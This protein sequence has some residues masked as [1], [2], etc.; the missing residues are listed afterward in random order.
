MA[1]ISGVVTNY[2]SPPWQLRLWSAIFLRG[3]FRDDRRPVYW[4]A[5]ACGDAGP[6]QVSRLGGGLM[7][8][9]PN[10]I[11]LVRFDESLTGVCD[12]GD[13]DFCMQLGPD[14]RL[15]VAP[16]ARLVHN[17]S[18]AGRTTGHW[19][20]HFS[21]TNCHLFY[22]NWRKGITNL[23][24]F[25]WLCVGMALAATAG[26][27]GRFSAAPWV[28]LLGGIRTGRRSAGCDHARSADRPGATAAAHKPG[29][30]FERK[31]CIGLIG[32]FLLLLGVVLGL[33]WFNH[34]YRGNF[35]D[36]PDESA[37][38]VT[39]L[40]VHDYLSGLHYLHPMRFAEDFYLHYPK[41][42]FGH[43]PPVFY[44]VQTVW[45]LLFST[46]HTSLMLLMAV[47]TAL[48][49]FSVFWMLDSRCG[50]SCAVAGAL[51]MASLPV[52]QSEVGM[53][54]ADIPLALFT[55]LA[56][57]SFARFLDGGRTRDALVFGGI[58]AIAVMTKGSALALALL[59]FVAIPLTKKWH[60]FRRP[61][62]WAS[63]AIVVVLCAPWYWLTLHLATAGDLAQSKPTLTYTLAAAR[64]YGWQFLTV[65][66]WGTGCMAAVGLII[67]LWR[68]FRGD[69]VDPVWAGMVGLLLGI[70]LV[71][72]IVPAGHEARY[73]LP[74]VAAEVALAVI[75]VKFLGRKLLPARFVNPASAAVLVCL[76]AGTGLAFPRGPSHGF[77]AVAR[78]VVSDPSLQ[79]APILVSSD[80]DG[81]GMMVAETAMLDHR[82]DHVVLRSSKV[83]ARCDWNGKNF[84]LL[85]ANGAQAEEYLESVPVR[86]VVIDRSAR[87]KGSRLERE[88]VESAIKDNPGSWKLAGAF[89]A[90][91]SGVQYPSAI[92]L[93][94][95]TGSTAKARGIVSINMKSKLGKTLVLHLGS[96]PIPVEK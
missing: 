29:L 7:S 21:Q 86:A 9:R 70:V 24:C 74:A 4:L 47:L 76:F 55:L 5:N 19:L 49:C 23:A 15:L 62:L 57:L 60:L 48:L 85:Y 79:K 38:Y 46:S 27:I 16:R 3:P 73:I 33:Q 1:G 25:L 78:A 95:F 13:V 28:S 52:V 77:G 72:C 6:V 45:T 50:T 11:G 26:S 61:A 91:R 94:L 43:W 92:K 40:M 88:L 36:Y 81:E 51:I 8:F 56:A 87:G 10:A 84:R 20:R 32:V 67:V 30:R 82:P 89:P 59:P 90:W 2:S 93:Y 12:G 66:G 58:S 31:R 37:Q 44:L 34:A 80:G 35:G 53:V 71:F 69:E 22:R 42:A 14:A 17:Q 83:L 75:G 54:M 68:A 96:V 41:V 63:A 65:M 39:G 64:F 18:P